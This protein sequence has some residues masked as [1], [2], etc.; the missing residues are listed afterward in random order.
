MKAKTYYANDLVLA[1]KRPTPNHL[2]IREGEG[3]VAVCLIRVSDLD[4]V[5]EGA[6]KAIARADGLSWRHRGPTQ[7]AF[8]IEA[9]RAAYRAGGFI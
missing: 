7:R 4:K 2:N 3:D 8:F 5:I 9:A 6:A 1:A